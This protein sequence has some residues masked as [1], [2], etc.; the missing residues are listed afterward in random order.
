MNR[1]NGAVAQPLGRASDAHLTLSAYLCVLTS[2][3]L[4]SCCVL[5]ASTQLKISS[6]LNQSFR[7]AILFPATPKLI[8]S[9]L[10][11]FLGT[12]NLILGTHNLFLG[13]PN[14]F[15]PTPN[16]FPGTPHLFLPAQNQFRGTPKQPHQRPKRSETRQIAQRNTKTLAFKAKLHILP[17]RLQPQV[18]NPGPRPSSTRPQAHFKGETS[19]RD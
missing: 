1:A 8:L 7:A 18:L 3:T 16:Q 11:Q 19:W 5:T 9:S 12:Q 15:L 10:N 2:R 17:P 13:T 14:L 6:T 4:R